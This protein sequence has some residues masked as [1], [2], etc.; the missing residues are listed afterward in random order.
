MG[1]PRAS[2]IDEPRSRDTRQRS[3]VVLPCRRFRP[4]ASRGTLS[5]HSA[6]R[7]ATPQFEH[8]NAGVLAP[9]SGRILRYDQC[10]LCRLNR[11]RSRTRFAR[12]GAVGAAR[13][14]RSERFA[15]EYSIILTTAIKRCCWLAPALLAMAQA[16][17]YVNPAQCAACH[18]EIAAAYARTGMARSFASFNPPVE[19]ASYYHEPS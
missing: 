15:P 1:R 17:T 11:R 18:A 10:A 9:R 7:G 19:A 2:L 6:R 13:W 4:G 3:P 16:A 12:S 8:S 14:G 5:R